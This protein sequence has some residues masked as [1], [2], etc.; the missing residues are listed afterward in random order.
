MPE[1]KGFSNRSDAQ[2]PRRLLVVGV[3]GGGCNTVSRMSESWPDGPELC[4]VNTDARALEDS[5]IPQQITIGRNL[6]RGMGAGGDLSVG[7]MAAEDDVDSLRSLVTQTDLVFIVTALGGGTGTGAAPVLARVAREEGA[8][9]LCFASL[10][11]DFEGENRKSQ[12][13]EGL[14]ILREHCDAVICLPNQRLMESL[15]DKTS[16]LE[17]FGAAD[18]VLGLQIRCLWRLLT[19][20][21]MINIDFS[22]VRNLAEAGGGVCCFGHGE[23]SG[24]LRTENALRAVLES[25]LLDRG[26]LLSQSGAALV[27]ISG[28]TD[29]TLVD[30]QK[31]M[32]GVKKSLRSD[33]RLTMG[34]LV[35]EAWDGHLAVM[36][37]AAD[38][39]RETVTA[40]P[41]RHTHAGETAPG[42]KP[43]VII[44]S[45]ESAKPAA[46]KKPAVQA[47]LNFDTSDKGRFSN[48]DPTLFNGEDLDIPTFLRRGIKIVIDR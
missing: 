20:G 36:V 5:P 31:V 15:T 4:V 37:L 40:P 2:R 39:R 41:A 34:A 25:P 45:V 10:P 16:V 28:G 29:L 35:D 12:A 27:S 14:Q 44:P 42:D 33:A 13:K 19:Q 46:G 8:L 43:P 7:K 26:R 17:A 21:G 6:T 38:A 11:F 32:Q 9:T 23:G 47:T 48:V 1:L 3:G 24:L 22:D 18:R 30:I